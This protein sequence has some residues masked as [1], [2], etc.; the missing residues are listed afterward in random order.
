MR[1]E[2][3]NIYYIDLTPIKLSEKKYYGLYLEV[4]YG[5]VFLFPPSFTFLCVPKGMQM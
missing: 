3:R 4:L 1:M 5:S 2:F